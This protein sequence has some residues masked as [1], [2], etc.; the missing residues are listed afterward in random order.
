MEKF[1]STPSSPVRTAEAS[2]LAVDNEVLDDSYTLS[3]KLIANQFPQN[4]IQKRS[5]AKLKGSGKK[6]RSGRPRHLV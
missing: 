6:N 2:L 1:P 5:G 3:E 4:V